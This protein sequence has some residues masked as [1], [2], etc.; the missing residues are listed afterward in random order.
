M[1]HKE[2]SLLK[3]LK[4]SDHKQP[5]LLITIHSHFLASVHHQSQQPH[6]PPNNPPQPKTM[7]GDSAADQ[8]AKK[9]L[10]QLDAYSKDT[11][12]K[13]DQPKKTGVKAAV[14]REVEKVVPRRKNPQPRDPG[15]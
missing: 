9:N 13:N 10:G 15:N 12:K 6:S 8:A 4:S 5:H 1:T 3:S 11:L 2:V 14:E 7:P